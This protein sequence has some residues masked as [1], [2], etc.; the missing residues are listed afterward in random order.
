MVR[1]GIF[2]AHNMNQ[3]LVYGDSLSWGIIP[4]TRKRLAFDRRWP[5]VLESSLVSAGKRVRIIED[6]LNGRRTV[7]DDPLKPGRN[8]IHGIGQRIEVNSPL[9]LVIVMLGTNDFQSSHNNNASQS[10]EGLRAVIRAIR[11]APIEPGMAMP[12]VLIASPPAIRA[13]EGDVSPKFAGAEIRS[14]GMAEAQRRVAEEERCAYFDCASVAITS[15]FDGV[16]MDADQHETL[17]REIAKHVARL[18]P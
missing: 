13:A 9:A 1:D 6:C 8:G 10:A 2:Q 7:W 4:N 3:V 16:H 12:E 18:L 17:G 14:I 11:A 15:P 5:G